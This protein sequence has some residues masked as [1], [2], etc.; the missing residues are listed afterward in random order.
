VFRSRLGTTFG[1]GGGGV[2]TGWASPESR[3][4]EWRRCRWWSAAS[5][6]GFGFP[7]IDSI[8]Y[9]DVG[10]VIEAKPTVTNAGYVEIEMKF[11]TSDIVSSGSDATNLTPSFTQ[12]SL[13][14][15]AA[16]PGWG[17][18]GRCRHQY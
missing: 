5:A 11:E 3:G 8:Q 13:N 10:L 15:T 12:R 2:G 9:R 18:G 6:G 4:R 1:F 17:H 14:T 16:H 7:G